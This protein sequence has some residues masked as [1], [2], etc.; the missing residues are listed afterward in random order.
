MGIRDY[1]QSQHIRF[2]TLLHRPMP[3][4][5]RFA[6]SV[7]VPGRSVAKVVLVHAGARYILTVLPATHRIDP[8]RLAHVL[9]VEQ[10]QIAS[11][12][13]VERVFADCERGALPPFGRLYGLTTVVDASLAGVSD[14]VFVGNARHEGVRMSYRDF[15]AIEDPVRARF[16]M[17][18]APRRRRASH[19][20]AG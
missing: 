16:A 3:S 6:Q 13:E 2:Q 18:I 10:V 5:T 11:E 4:A 9:G 14:I 1:L 15:E 12:D 20:R 8:E 19:R 7:H 17:A